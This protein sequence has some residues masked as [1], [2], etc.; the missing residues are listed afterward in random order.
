MKGTH[1]AEMRRALAAALAA[2]PNL[3]RRVTVDVD[4]VSVL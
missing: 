1:R 3:L 2:R 4:P